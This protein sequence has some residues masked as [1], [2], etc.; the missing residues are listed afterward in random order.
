MWTSGTNG[1]VCACRGVPVVGAPGNFVTGFSTTKGMRFLAAAAKKYG[2]TDPR[3]MALTR[4][5]Y[6][7]TWGEAGAGKDVT[8]APEALRDAAR[9][10]GLL[11]DA[12]ELIAASASDDGKVRCAVQHTQPLTCPTER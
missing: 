5:V 12:D 8:L 9:R 2:E 1:A 7:H 6:A 3:L 4:G 11:E 10:A